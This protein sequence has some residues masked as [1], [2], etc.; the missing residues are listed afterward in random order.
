VFVDLTA[1]YDTVWYRDLA[2]KLL[3]L[4]PDR[5]MVHMIM[6]MDGNCSVTLTTGNGLRCL[7]NGV[8]QRTTLA[9]LLFNIY[10][11]YQPNTV[12]RKYAYTD[13]LAIVHADG[14]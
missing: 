10:I 9:P 2:S 4:L 13:D 6:E 5:H 7:K 14:D 3:R 11:S 8:P 12:S 1:A